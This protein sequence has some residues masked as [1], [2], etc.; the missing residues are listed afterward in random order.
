VKKKQII[1]I[2]LATATAAAGAMTAAAFAATSTVEVREAD[3]VEALSD[4]R[5]TGHYEFLR[6]G[7]HV[8]TEGNTGTDKVA[9]YFPVTGALPTSGG[10]EWFGTTPAPGAQIVFDVDGTT[11]NG[12]DFNILVGESIYGDD[13]WL[14]NGSSDA[15]KA[16]DPSGPENGG[17]GSEWFGTLEEWKTALPNARTL[18]GGFSLGSGV[19]GDGVIRAVTLGEVT[20]EFTDQAAPEVPPTPEVV[21][22]TGDAK[23]KAIGKKKVKVTLKSDATPAGKAEGDA[24]EWTIE[25]D[26]AE[27]ATLTQGAGEKDVLFYTFGKNTGKHKVVVR[28]DGKKVESLVINTSK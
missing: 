14:S 13:W 24:L 9:E 26:G 25:V 19:K 4:T 12:N 10:L 8:W 17:S 28:A 3:F 18:A 20:Y 16:A 6:E 1:A 22:V 27:V 11:G 21:D 15:A 7:I 23:L 5:A 2:S